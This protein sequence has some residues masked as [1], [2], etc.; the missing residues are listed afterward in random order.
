MK[1]FDVDNERYLINVDW[2]PTIMYLA[3]SGSWTS[4]LTDA[5][6]DG[7][8]IWPSLLAS[9][10][11]DRTEMIHDIESET[12]FA[13]ESVSNNVKLIYGQS[14]NLVVNVQHVFSEDQEP[15]SAAYE[16][17]DDPDMNSSLLLE[18]DIGDDESTAAAE[19][20][21]E[22]TSSND[23][24]G[25]A[26]IVT[27]ND[28]QADVDASGDDNNE[29]DEIAL[30]DASEVVTDTND[31]TDDENSTVKTI[32]D[33]TFLNSHIGIAVW[34]SVLLICTISGVKVML[35]RIPRIRQLYQPIPDGNDD[36]G[37]SVIEN[38]G[39]KVHMGGTYGASN[40]VNSRFNGG[41]FVYFSEAVENNSNFA[42]ASAYFAT[43]ARESPILG[44]P[45]PITGVTV[46]SPSSESVANTPKKQAVENSVVV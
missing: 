29:N 6:I 1:W 34:A 41:G 46:R 19:G 8:N 32:E 28:D 31:N 26:D 22:S 16:C 30:D 5:D 20:D 43:S 9:E 18:E 24:D 23:D 11:T 14:D 36:K 44:P 4:G 33:V 2:F 38:V 21:D 17:T 35:S 12:T 42:W 3:T 13:V 40:P 37:A 39:T 27:S 10:P 15:Q 45:S 7:Y 25:S